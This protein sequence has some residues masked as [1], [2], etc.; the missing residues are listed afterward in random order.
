MK[1]LPLPW[2][3]LACFGAVGTAWAQPGWRHG[4]GLV[5]LPPV[6]EECARPQDRCRRS[7][8]K[9]RYRRTCWCCSTEVRPLSA[10]TPANQPNRE[11]GDSCGAP[12]PPA[13]QAAKSDCFL[14]APTSAPP[15]RAVA[16][17]PR[18]T[19]NGTAT[20]FERFLR[21]LKPKATELRR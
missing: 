4:P 7:P 18:Y 12:I 2:F 10:A 8:W 19:T 6:T 21:S 17:L 14:Y 16:P 13:I 5:H 1:C 9:I 3:F 20:D 15:T 11:Y